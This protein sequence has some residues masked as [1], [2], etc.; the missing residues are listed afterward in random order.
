MIKVAFRLGLRCWPKYLI[1][2]IQNE[3]GLTE[4]KNYMFLL[5][6]DRYKSVD[7]QAIKYGDTSSEESSMHYV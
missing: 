5:P 7:Y 4:T 2:G 1:V 6:T 3:K